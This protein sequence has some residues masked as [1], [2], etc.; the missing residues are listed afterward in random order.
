MQNSKC[1]LRKKRRRNHGIAE[2]APNERLTL[3]RQRFLGRGGQLGREGE[4]GKERKRKEERER[5]N[6]AIRIR[7][8]AGCT[9][10]DEHTAS[11]KQC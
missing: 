1:Q 7:A 9:R 5:K 6:E 10:Q 8:E 4:R 11:P 2:T 3:E